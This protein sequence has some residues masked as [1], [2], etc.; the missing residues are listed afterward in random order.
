MHLS[1]IDLNLFVVFDAIFSEGSITRAG[2]RLNLSQPAISHA[3]ARLRGLCDDP[4][5]VRN[6]H[7]MAPTPRARQMISPVRDALQGFE[8]SLASTDRF[9]PGAVGKRF[10]IGV[11]GVAEPIV[12]PVLMRA[13]AKAAPRV[14][15][16][17]VRPDRRELERELA[18]GTIDLAIDVLLP[19]PDDIRRLHL[20]AERLTVVARRG[21][22]KLG[23]ALTL[24]GYLA[25]EHIQVSQRRRG[26]SAEDFELSRQDLRRRVRLRCQ[27]YFGACRVVSATDLVLTMP[28]RY[29]R[30][31]NPHFGNRL[32]PFPLDVAAFDTYAY[33]HANSDD[34]P[35][36]RWL[37]SQVFQTFGKTR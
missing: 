8:A 9:D 17:L 26:L 24:A 36:N 35:A 28:E 4:L 31:I 7:A 1:R 25:L 11:Q 30:I 5:F 37:R 15:I 12:A 19:L 13:I 34:D 3:L 16:S 14:D 2:R 10:V 23:K 32:L 18:A 6:G 20:G 22:P 27:N 29:A 21:H 33:W